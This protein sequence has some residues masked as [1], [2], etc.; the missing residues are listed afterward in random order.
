MGSTL[1]ISKG[2]LRKISFFRGVNMPYIGL[3]F[4]P[5]LILFLFT[6]GSDLNGILCQRFRII[7]VF[8]SNLYF[9]TW[10]NKLGYKIFGPRN[11]QL[12]LFGQGVVKILWSFF[13]SLSPLESK[14]LNFLGRKLS[15][16]GAL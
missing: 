2:G 7:I 1:F 15:S 10:T 16:D 6:L 9:L 8:V 4:G 12:R 5:C 14:K 11:I 13:Y 3:S